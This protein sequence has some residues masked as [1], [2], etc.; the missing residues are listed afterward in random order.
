[1]N[2]VL[3]RH[4]V[5]LSAASVSFAVGLKNLHLCSLVRQNQPANE[6]N[7]LH[8]LKKCSLFKKEEKKWSF[9]FII[10]SSVIL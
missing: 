6:E 8:L 2:K 1:M 10:W 7:L 5:C 4:H 9:A 3:F